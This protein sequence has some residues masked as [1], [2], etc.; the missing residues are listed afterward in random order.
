M[1]KDYSVDPIVRHDCPVSL[2]PYHSYFLLVD[3]GTL[4]KYGGEIKLRAK[5]EKCISEENH[6]DSKSL[7]IL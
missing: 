5:L 3:D 1:A 7:L 4:R 2:N 6:E